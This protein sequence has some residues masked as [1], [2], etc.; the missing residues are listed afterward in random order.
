MLKLMNKRIVRVICIIIAFTLSLSTIGLILNNNAKNTLEKRLITEYSVQEKSVSEGVASSLASQIQN[1]KNSLYT[2]ALDQDIQTGDQSTCN[3]KLKKYHESLKLGLGNLGRVGANGKFRCSLN[4]ALQ[5][6]PANKLGNYLD[7]LFNDPSHP[8]VVSRQLK[9]PN[10]SGYIVAIHVPVFDNKGNFVGS[11]GGAIYLN[12]LVETYL[13]KIKFA[14]TG[15]AGLQDDN[16]DFLYTQKVDF[17]N[18][19][20]FSHEIQSQVGNAAELSNAIKAGYAGKSSI[21]SYSISGIDKIA[22]ITSV[23]LTPQHHWIVIVNVPKKEIAA[24][25]FGAGLARAFQ[26]VA[27]VLISALLLIA[28]I[29]IVGSVREE[30]LQKNKDDFVSLASHQLRTPATGVKQYLGILLHGYAGKLTPRQREAVNEADKSNERQLAIIEEL[31]NV[32]RIDSGHL[33]LVSKPV[34]MAILTRSVSKEMGLQFSAKQQRYTQNITSRSAMILGDETY[35][36]MVIE[37]LVSNAIKYTPNNG[38]I[39]VDLSTNLSHVILS[40]QDTG[41]GIAPEDQKRLFKKFSRINNNQSTTASGNGLGLYLV[42]QIVAQHH[43]T[44]SVSL[45]LGHG[46]K[47]SVQLPRRK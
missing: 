10:V 16:G 31:L 21:V 18:K 2:I 5:D 4:P 45:Q 13:S 11:L 43:G 27:I 37:N 3:I 9:V 15:F 41:V 33:K 6:T 32:M 36:R 30:S 40:I 46:S 28:I 24:T 47:F 17:L 35:M 39:S 25:F 44:I 14:E 23:E 8:T 29:V 22:S 34:D 38:E 12:D 19:N 7:P 26:T 20:Y 1:I 42:K